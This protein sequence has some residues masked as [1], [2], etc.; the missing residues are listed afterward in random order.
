[1]IKTIKK[2]LDHQH[3]DL[4]VMG[5]KGLTDTADI[6][7]GSNA[8]QVVNKLNGCPIMAIPNEMDYTAPKEIAFVTDYTADRHPKTIAP[9]L[10]IASLIKT[11]IRVMHINKDQVLNR[12]QENNSI[13]LEIFL[14]AV[15]QNMC[16]F[17]DKAK[18]VETFLDKMHIDLFAMVNRKMNLFERM[19]HEPVIKDVSM[20]SDVPFLMLPDKS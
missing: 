6:F 11:T 3:T 13:H 2:Q 5:N 17:D 4:I 19:K 18:V 10:Y 12:T 1:M 8:I 7:F 14:E 20:Y 16:E 9:L 15:T